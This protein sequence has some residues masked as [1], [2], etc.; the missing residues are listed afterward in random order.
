MKLDQGRTGAPRPRAI[1]RTSS[2][3]ERTAATEAL[4]S[5][6]KSADHYL[7]EFSV[8]VAQLARHV[9]TSLGMSASEVADLYDAALLK[10]IGKLSIP[11]SIKNKPGPLS[12][13]E[14]Q[15][16]RTHPALS[17]RILEG[18]P[19]LSHLADVVLH[20][21]EK[22]DG[23]GYPDGLSGENIPLLA[24][25]IAACDVLVSLVTHRPY[26]R[27]FSQEEALEVL[28]QISGADLDKDVVRILIRFVPQDAE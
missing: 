26:R 11:D 3:E 8:R 7:Y 1:L 10:D 9:G 13:P 19:S 21:H 24:R 2:P 6:L 15:V 23:S 28:E 12:E 16:L 4:S 25:I 22:V 14:W 20:H 17:A 27:A 5:T 18:I